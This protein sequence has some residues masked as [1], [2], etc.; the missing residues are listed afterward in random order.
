MSGYLTFVFDD[1][2]E[3]VLNE[4]VPML[5]KH[6]IP[7]V[8]AVPI[9]SQAVA[10]QE[11]IATAGPDRWLPLKQS[12]HEIAAHSISHADLTKLNKTQLLS[13]LQQPASLL[14]AQT[15]VYPGGAYNQTVTTA[16]SRF[17]RFARTVEKGFEKIPPAEPMALKTYNFTTANYRVWKANL[18]A[19]WACINNLW[20][21]ETFHLVSSTPSSY[22]Y[23]VSL[24]DFHRHLNFIRKL[25][26]KIRTI[27]S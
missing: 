24:K 12:G 8:F 22:P 25:P 18:L 14:H 10:A 4:V 7:A 13:E 15:L 19:V 27:S 2:Y 17:Y 20:L 5:N 26:I 6:K 16:A 9:Q 3:P 11:K 21:I 23:F 1:G